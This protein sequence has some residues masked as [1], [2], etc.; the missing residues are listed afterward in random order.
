MRPI[1]T[2]LFASTYCRDLRGTKLQYNILSVN[3]WNNTYLKRTVNEQTTANKRQVWFQHLGELKT[4]VLYPWAQYFQSIVHRFNWDTSIQLVPRFHHSMIRLASCQSFLNFSSKALSEFSCQRLTAN[5]QKKQPK[6]LLRNTVHVGQREKNTEK[7]G[8]THIHSTV[9]KTY[10]CNLSGPW[11]IVGACNIVKTCNPMLARTFFTFGDLNKPPGFSEKLRITNFDQ[12]QLQLPNLLH[13]NKPPMGMELWFR[14]FKTHPA[15]QL[16]KAV[17]STHVGTISRRENKK[18]VQLWNRICI[19]H[20]SSWPLWRR[21]TCRMPGDMYLQPHG[22]H[23][24]ISDSW[25]VCHKKNGLE[26]TEISKLVA[27]THMYE[28]LK[29]NYEQYQIS[30]NMDSIISHQPPNELKCNKFK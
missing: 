14:C 8:I 24:T 19:V 18:T 29:N 5:Q 10:H 21:N 28:K 1:T 25:V 4:V 16:L 9:E 26:I 20:V 15:T 27:R 23:V 12:K 3:K 13:E 7:R 17:Q 2:H 30:L 6:D 22:Q 11:G